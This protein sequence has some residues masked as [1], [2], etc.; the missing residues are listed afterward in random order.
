M[1]MIK[2]E[3]K[4]KISHRASAASALTS[5]TG[6]RRRWTPTWTL[7]IAVPSDRQNVRPGRLIPMMETCMP[8]ILSHRTARPHPDET[9]EAVHDE[10]VCTTEPAS[11]RRREG[12]ATPIALYPAIGPRVAALLRQLCGGLRTSYPLHNARVGVEWQSIESAEHE[13]GFAPRWPGSQ[14]VFELPTAM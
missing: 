6:S 14:P 5:S 4:E 10:V 12:H 9:S 2:P 7:F 1:T 13:P 11:L 8:D 3:M